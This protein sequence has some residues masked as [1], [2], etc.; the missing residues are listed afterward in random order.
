MKE[1]SPTRSRRSTETEKTV[2]FSGVILIDYKNFLGV[3]MIIILI[4][5]E[6]Y[7]DFCVSS[8]MSSK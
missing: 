1:S 5:N 2:N 6:T 3:S 7:N 4:A 8:F